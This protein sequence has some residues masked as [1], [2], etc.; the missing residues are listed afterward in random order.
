MQFLKTFAF[1][2]AIRKNK[3]P[4]LVIPT[5]V[6]RSDLLQIRF[7][8]FGLR[9]PLEM[10][11]Y[12]SALLQ[13]GDFRRLEA[14]DTDPPGG[15]APNL[16]KYYNNV[17]STNYSTQYQRLR[18]TDVTISSKDWP[19]LNPLP[20]IRGIFLALSRG[21]LTHGFVLRIL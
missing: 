12:F 2:S 4:S 8:D 3:Y 14:K 1:L 6:E 10:T 16:P 9:P 5:G 18:R 13:G 17:S 11:V 21:G 20:P 15:N 7:L 19:C